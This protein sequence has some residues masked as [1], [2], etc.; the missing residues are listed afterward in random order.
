M[1]MKQCNEQQAPD[2]MRVVLQERKEAGG[3]LTPDQYAYTSTLSCF[4]KVKRRDRSSIIDWHLPHLEYPAVNPHAK[5]TWQITN[6]LAYMWCGR[7]DAFLLARCGASCRDSRFDF[8]CCSIRQ[9]RVRVCAA[10]G[11]PYVEGM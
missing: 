3:I 5:F 8:G 4:G 10:G 6:A 11:L 1:V 9:V 7:C 2:V